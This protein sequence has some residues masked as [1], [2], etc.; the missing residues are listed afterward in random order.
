[1]EGDEIRVAF[2]HDEG[3]ERKAESDVVEGVWFRGVC[4]GENCR[5]DGDFEGGCHFLSSMCW[6]IPEFVQL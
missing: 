1:M 3:A 5:G 2:L 4:G 6:W